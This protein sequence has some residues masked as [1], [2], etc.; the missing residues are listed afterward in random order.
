MVC[1][2]ERLIFVGSTE[3]KDMFAYAPS[4]WHFYEASGVSAL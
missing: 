2:T 1:I 3:K 4:L